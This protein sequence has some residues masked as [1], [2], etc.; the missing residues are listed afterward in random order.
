MTQLQDPHLRWLHLTDLHVGK[1]SEPQ[2][3][4]LR[5]L[6]QSIVT[7]SETKPFDLVLLTGDLVYSGKLAEF[8][9][10][11]K[12]VILPLRASPLCRNATFMAVPGNHDLD[13]DVGCPTS[14]GGIGSNRQE[15]FFNLDAKGARTRM[16][17]SAAFNEYRDFIARNNILGADPTTVPAALHKITVRGKI[18]LFVPLVTSFFS[19]K[20]VSDFQKAPMPVQPIRALLQ[21]SPSAENVVL[22]LGHHPS[23]WFLA[24]TERRF[25][26]LTDEYSVLYLHGHQH[27]VT[28][29]FS[30]R[31]LISLGFGA[32]YQASLDSNP[33]PYYRNSFAICELD[34]QLHV[35]VFSWDAENG[36]WRLDQNLPVDFRE[37]SIRL[38]GG[39]KLSLP[40]TVLAATTTTPYS[41]LAAAVKQEYKIDRCVWLA[42]D[43]VKRWT[44]VLISMGQVAHVSEAFKL[45]SQ[46]LP[47]G[48]VQ[49]RLKDSRGQYLV[50]GISA[51]GDVLNYEQLQKINTELDTQDYAGCFILTLGKLAREARTLADQLSVR[52]SLNVIERAEIVKSCV[53][54]FTTD[55]S[56][57]L[58]AVDIKSSCLSLAIT[59]A[60]CALLLE[61]AA[62]NSWYSVIDERGAIA[63][64]A[65][66]LVKQLK[67]ATPSLVRMQYETSTNSDAR[68]PEELAP[69]FDRTEYLRRSHA[70][71]DDVKYAP[72]AALGLRFKKTSLS[73]MYVSA[74]ADVGGATKTSQNATRALTEFMETLGLAKPQREQLEAQLR[75]RFGLDRTAE[76]GAA[77][78]LYQRYNNIVVLGDPGS[79]KTCFLKNEI[80]S[81]C[82]AGPENAGWYSSHLPVYVSLAE[83]AKLFGE[84][85]DLLEICAI[86]SARR[87]IELPKD[88]IECELA[89]G[90]AAL[91]FDGLDEVGFIDKRIG[92]M[93][94]IGKLV[95][96]YAPR[97][98]RFVLA[99]RPAAVQPV[100]V[101]EAFTYVQLKG[102]TEDEMRVLA[103]RVMTARLG[104]ESAEPLE[105]EENDLIERLLDDTRNSP[106]IGRIAR[107]PLLLT[108]LVLIYA[109]TGALTAKRH[110]IYTQAIKTLVSVRGREVRENQV[111]EA[112]LRTRLGA[113]AVAIFSRE[114]DEIPRRTDVVR[115]LAKAMANGRTEIVSPTV[116]NGFIQEVAEATGL[117]SIHSV[118]D[119]ASPEDLITF[120][121][122]SFLEYYTAAGLL[123]TDYEQVLTRL[124]KNPRWKD[125][126]TLMFGILSDY[127]DVTP[128]LRTL[129]RDDTAAGLITEYK[130]LLAL[131][132][133]SECDVPPESAQDLLGD[134]VFKSLSM[135]AGR[136]SG[137][138]REEIASKLQYFLSGSGPRLENVLVRG[139]D[140]SDAMVVAA[141]CHLLA[142]LDGGI[143]LAPRIQAAFERALRIE[144]P[145]VQTAAMIA[146]EE[147]RSLRTLESMRVVGKALTGNVSEKH[148]ALKII[149]SVPEFRHKFPE[150]VRELLDDSNPLISELAANSVLV[151]GLRGGT[152]LKG[153]TASDKRV[154]EKVLSKLNQSD[155][156]SAVSISEVTLHHSVIEEMFAIGDSS[157][158]ELAIRYVSMIKNDSSYVHRVLSRNLRGSDNGRIRAACM[159]A[160]RLAPEALTLVNIAD[161]DFI[162]SLLEADERNVRL[163]ALKL[164]GEL[165]D[166]EQVVA[167]LRNVLVSLRHMKD[168]EA[169]AVEAAKS[170][171]KHVKRNPRLR[172]DVLKIILSYIPLA[173]KD[174]FGSDAHQ[175]HMRTMLYVV[176]TIGGID[177]PAAQRAMALAEDY[178]TPD[179]LRR[180]AIRVFGRLA[181]PTVENVKRLCSLLDKNDLRLKEA[182]F[183]AVTSFVKRCRAKVEYVRRVYQSFSALR[184]GLE[185]AWVRETAG[186]NNSIDPAG[187]HEIRAAVV[188]IENLTAAYEEFSERAATTGGER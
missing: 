164:L 65:S 70:Y 150:K 30:G 3:I 7:N 86:Q 13:C 99:S 36:S 8:E 63:N 142:S 175:N 52:K 93:A 187:A 50:H 113:V 77:S 43:D 80:L 125:V 104:E 41:L 19:D 170:L 25:Q 49:F 153:D 149:C 154:R 68:V 105:K 26:T 179:A 144:N 184:A 148:G 127:R 95:K 177:E 169:E 114:V 138:V 76:V 71:F 14:W 4:A 165:P 33:K 141:F 111:S 37:R 151:N 46:S 124:S 159:D 135:G 136:Y 91:F 116:V 145:S 59:Q 32:S 119:E 162:C 102:L 158:H 88:V 10:L 182:V 57:L 64:E 185:R 180:Q 73:E 161:T 131:D 58:T 27:I 16:S 67:E 155:Q 56:E 132:C 152:W 44:D 61:D 108:L 137:T 5:S 83:A 98:N 2:R 109:N 168:R 163:A 92:L 11:E 123:A 183:P 140:S 22:V 38:N 101:P 39:Y 143:E 103:G 12:E 78:Q 48:H 69:E 85:A 20:E 18:F 96:A 156:E 29:K 121:H 81:Y 166:D 42:G 115:V 117:I 134:A 129:L 51:Y 160:L 167:S 188:E 100:D 28:A 107:N 87:G 110:I 62:K 79:G 55:Q 172:E 181:E 122:F 157:I 17:R 173:A 6:I 72:L 74:S 94:E 84:H 178:R 146:I 171:A 112:D 34:D 176:E 35:Q 60:G 1:D 90:R 118:N 174:G 23:S 15:S 126:T 54:S 139:L 128:D 47:A 106:G 120:M 31:G 186:S 45:P 53:R 130:L 82:L 24:E 9:A 97:G 21:E 75:S 133:A 89:S 40:S 147:H 66:Q